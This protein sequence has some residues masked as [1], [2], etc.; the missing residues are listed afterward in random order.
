MNLEGKIAGY[1][2]KTLVIVGALIIVAGGIFYIGAKY[3]KRKLANLPKSDTCA[4]GEAKSNKKNSKAVIATPVADSISGVITARDLNSMT[5][6]LIDGSKVH[7]NLPEA[8]LVIGDSVTASGQYYND[9]D[10]SFSGK[11]ITKDVTKPAT[12]ANNKSTTTQT[13][14]AK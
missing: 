8:N 7:I 14:T 13:G 2:K 9:G 1:S 6:K 3:E 4:I 5:I 10:G 11:T 12:T